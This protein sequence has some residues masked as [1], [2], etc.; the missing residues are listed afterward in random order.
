[1]LFTTDTNTA[2]L[3]KGG[4]FRLKGL[5][6][7]RG[8]AV[9]LMLV[10]H[11]FYD[12]I[13]L[14][15]IQTFFQ[16][17]WFYPLHIVIV[18][19]FMVAAGLAAGIQDC[20]SK[21]GVV[22]QALAALLLTGVTV[23][24]YLAIEGFPGYIL[25]NVLHVLA[26]A[27]ILTYLLHGR[28]QKKVLVEDAKLAARGELYE[29]ED[30]AYG[31]PLSLEEIES[32]DCGAAVR[33]CEETE[34]AKVL[35]AKARTQRHILQREHKL[36]LYLL[37]FG[38]FLV[39]TLVRSRLFHRNG[40]Q[41]LPSL[42]FLSVFPWLFL[43]LIVYFHVKENDYVDSWAAWEQRHDL[44]ILNPLAFLGRHALVIYFVHQPVIWLVLKAVTGWL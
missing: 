15:G 17:E 43:Y 10:H 40:G 36:F 32:M 14:F 18:G 9:L 3:A 1:M 34:E 37:A 31:E 21:R 39:E 41:P 11:T 12:L 2:P 30:E 13:Y 44:K 26:V 27:R 33:Y 16:T 35:S 7:L 19:L 28:I 6:A 38:A 8:L 20:P 24:A 22:R 42:D 25:W 29:I 4:A 23:V 5:D